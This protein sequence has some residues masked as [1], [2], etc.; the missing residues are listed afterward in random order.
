MRGVDIARANIVLIHDLARTILQN[1]A[2]LGN[3]CEGRR[4]NRFVLH[5][6][7]RVRKTAAVRLSN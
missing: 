1:L 7:F 4:V 6:G 2:Y 3:F 5:I